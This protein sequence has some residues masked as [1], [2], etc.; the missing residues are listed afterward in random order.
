MKQPAEFPQ[1]RPGIHEPTSWQVIAEFPERCR[2][3]E[4]HFEHLRDHISSVRARNR[5]E[6]EKEN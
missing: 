1:R 5:D 3:Y 4:T 6:E 2:H